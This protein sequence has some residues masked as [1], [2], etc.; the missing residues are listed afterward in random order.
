MPV[1]L[2]DVNFKFQTE[3]FDFLVGVR[4]LPGRKP[5][6]DSFE[7]IM[8]GA[9]FNI[10]T[11]DKHQSN[12][13]VVYCRQIDPLCLCNYGWNHKYRAW[14][15]ADHALSNAAHENPLEPC[16]AMGSHG[17][18]VYRPILGLLNNKFMGATT[19]SDN[20]FTRY[21]CLFDFFG[22]TFKVL[23]G[24]LRHFLQ[25]VRPSRWRPERQKRSPPRMRLH[26]RCKSSDWP[27]LLS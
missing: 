15:A 17:N 24:L 21:T 4:R 13:W 18:Q 16:S 23:P 1:P 10:R 14:C 3:G 26:K 19:H 22:G 12:E 9:G 8:A 5:A 7:W 6:P 20:L 11:E 2:G 27:A 25:D